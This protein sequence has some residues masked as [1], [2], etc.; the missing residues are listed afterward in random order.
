MESWFFSNLLTFRLAIDTRLHQKNRTRGGKPTLSESSKNITEHRGL[1]RQ[2]RTPMNCFV[3][4][5]GLSW[6]HSSIV[7]NGIV[8]K[9]GC[10]TSRQMDNFSQCQLPTK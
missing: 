5:E 4:T 3:S 10:F 8:I 9:N 1:N 7:F 2:A 6:R